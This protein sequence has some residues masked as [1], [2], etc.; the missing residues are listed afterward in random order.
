[1]GRGPKGRPQ[2]FEMHAR[3]RYLPGTGTYGYEDAH[4]DETDG[5]VPAQVVGHTPKRVRIRFNNQFGNLVTRA[6]DAAS[7]IH[8]TPPAAVAIVEPTSQEATR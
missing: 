4:R 5:R 1:M 6:V 7:L 2:D 3:V 8:E